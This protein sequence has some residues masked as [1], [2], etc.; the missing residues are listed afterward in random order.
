MADKEILTTRP[1]C[2]STLCDPL[3][4][5]PVLDLYR[6]DV[7]RTLLRENLKLS[8]EERLAKLIGF[9]SAMAS[10]RRENGLPAL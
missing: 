1:G 4:P 7:D 5:D 9:A 3:E 8:S 6:K 2:I 10:L